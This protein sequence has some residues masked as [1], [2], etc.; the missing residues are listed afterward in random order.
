MTAEQPPGSTGRRAVGDIVGGFVA[1]LYSVPEGIG[2]ASLA[3]IS[4]MLG[5]YAG[6][7]P[8]AVA[9]ATTGSMLMM[10]T[11]TSAIAL[12]VAG[13]LDHG[14]YPT[15]QVP[16]AVF[17][18]TLLAGAIMVVLGLL[19]LGKVVAFISNA[20]MTGF[21]M[22]VA[23]LIMVGKLDEIVGYDPDG[24]SNKVVKA[25][26][27]VVHAGQWDWT[28]AAVGLTTIAAAFGLKA[29]PALDRYALVL[30]VIAGTAI[31][32][33]FGIATPTIAD[34]ATIATGLDAIPIPT[35]SS[36][37]PSIALIPGLFIGS[38]SIAIVALAQG[39][40]I[41]PAFPNPT[42]GRADASRDFLG[43]GLGNVGGAFFQSA[44]TG[45]SLSRT[46][47]SAEGGATRRWAGLVAALSVLALVVFAGS[48]VSHIPEA[49]IGGLLFVIGVELVVGRIP[50]ARLARDAGTLSLILFFVTLALT[51]TVPLQWA[52]LVGTVL[53]LL[54][55]IAR[56]TASARLRRIDRDAEGWLL[57]DDIPDTLPADEPLI[58]RYTGPDFFAV[59][60]S[61]VDHLPR[62]D[63]DHPGVLVLDL[64]RVDRYSSTMLKQ[65]ARYATDLLDAG[66]GLV[67]AGVTDHQREVL[68]RAGIGQ[69][70]GSDNLL[71]RDPHIDLTIE[72]AFER[73]RTHLAELKRGKTR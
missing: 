58:V 43:Q 14:A 7:T 68:A 21:V 44:P 66:S 70:I 50:D 24:I 55:Y 32:W 11:L 39:A 45:G 4:P 35:N 60:T 47:V 40:G 52:I 56:G 62:A 37:L 6:M 72:Q 19:R 17:T 26:D 25:V 54:A 51:L 16:Q 15:D 57:T 42:G 5:I 28:T 46:A 36:E 73:G 12:T 34:Q 59:V 67:V 1:G 20:V 27:I 8:V 38:I 33:I 31:V 61:I 69:R 23:V 22:G 48:F 3:G 65:L 64:G 63:P 10:S 9:A 18:M 13:V 2:Y 49:V 41:S 30:V 53:S 29:I 71:P